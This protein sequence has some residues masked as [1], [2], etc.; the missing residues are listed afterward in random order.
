MSSNYRCYATSSE[1]KA[2][3]RHVEEAMDVGA[4]GTSNSVDY[5][6]NGYCSV[7]ESY[8]VIGAIAKKGGLFSSQWR[9]TGLWQGFGNPGFIEWYKRSH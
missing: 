6:L 7:G 1:V 2:M 9:R 3:K 5:A 4:V 8:E